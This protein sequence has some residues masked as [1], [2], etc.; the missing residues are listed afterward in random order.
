MKFRLRMMG[1]LLLAVALVSGA[2]QQLSRKN[3]SSETG[4]VLALATA[5][6]FLNA[7]QA[8]DLETGI[9]L[10]SDHARK[11]QSAESMEDLFSPGAARAFEINHG[12][13]DHGRY[14]FPVVMVFRKSDH[15]HRK[16]SEIV[17]VNSGKDDWVVDRLP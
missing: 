15:L 5:N 10:L 1:L 12:K 3:N 17:L 4:Y 8:G 7:W 2:G 6:R 9:V 11:S 13:R 16:F 14:R